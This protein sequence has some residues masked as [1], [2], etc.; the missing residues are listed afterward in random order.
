[1]SVMYKKTVIFLLIIYTSIP[2]SFAIEPYV[3]EYKFIK[4]SIKFAESQHS[5]KKH[6]LGWSINSS[7]EPSG[8]L[9]LFY[10]NGKL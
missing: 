3:A 4:N 7:T 2:F 8:I 5:L 6:E 1:M 9:N 10:K